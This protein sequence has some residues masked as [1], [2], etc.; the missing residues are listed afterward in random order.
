MLSWH[1]VLEGHGIGI[2][3]TGMLIVFSGLSLIS[4]FIVALPRV[5]DR[6]NRKAAAAS[7]AKAKA[8]AETPATDED[9]LTVLSAVVHMELEQSHGEMKNLTIDREKRK[10]SAWASV[11][12]MRSLSEGGPHA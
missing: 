7:V 5:L 11:G 10:G 2:S 8:D 9:L 6:S 1:N 3:I 4:L 12:K